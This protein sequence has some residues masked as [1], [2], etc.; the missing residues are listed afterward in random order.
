[1]SA[2]ALTSV[3]CVRSL[4]NTAARDHVYAETHR[5]AG[6]NQRNSHVP[7]AE[8]LCRAAALAEARALDLTA[9]ARA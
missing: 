5:R 8:R 3:V 7:R 6:R 4:R 1:M 9:Q 2:A